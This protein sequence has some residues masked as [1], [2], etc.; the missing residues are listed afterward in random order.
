[1]G[2]GRVQKTPVSAEVPVREA[3]CLIAFRKKQAA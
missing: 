2:S 1:M 3:W